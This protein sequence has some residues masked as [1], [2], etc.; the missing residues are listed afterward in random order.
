[1]SMCHYTSQGADVRMS[2]DKLFYDYQDIIELIGCS[3]RMAYRLMN[4]CNKELNAKGYITFKGKVSS[5]Y[6]N[7]R[8]GLKVL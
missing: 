2:N 1:M 8:I 3:K 7:E 4:T 6:L 5:V